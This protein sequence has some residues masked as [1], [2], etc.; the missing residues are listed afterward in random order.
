[1]LSMEAVQLVFVSGLKT[2]NCVRPESRGSTALILSCRCAIYVTSPCTPVQANE[3]LRCY[4][5]VVA[6]TCMLSLRCYLHVVAA[7][8]PACRRCYLHVVAV[9]CM[10]SLRYH[11]H[12]VAATCT[13]SLRCYLHVVAVTCMLAIWLWAHWLPYGCGS[14]GCHMAVGPLVAKW[15]WAHWLPYGCGPIGCPMAVQGRTY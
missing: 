10:L 12:V 5:H 11:L 4:L 8:L 3:Q 2:Q 15:M 1:M 14:I 6:V 7:L 13:L 9:T